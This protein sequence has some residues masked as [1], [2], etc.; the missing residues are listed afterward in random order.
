MV[1]GPQNPHLNKNE[2]FIAE[3][4]SHAKKG[5]RSA[6]TRGTKNGLAPSPLSGT[7][8]LG[9]WLSGIL[10]RGRRIFEVRAART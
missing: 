10:H 4:E 2:F 5:D 7:D 9:I 8:F 1:H 3:L 6:H